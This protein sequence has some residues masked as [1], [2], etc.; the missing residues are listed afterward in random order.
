MPEA[1]TTESKIVCVHQGKAR[2]TAGQSKLK[3]GGAPAL[4]DGD[5]KQATLEPASCTNVGAGLVPCS[6]LT[7]L[8]GGVAAKLTVGGLGVLLADLKG[9]TN[10]TAPGTFLVEDAAQTRLRAV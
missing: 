1:I 7:P 2:L 4:V 9:S 5:I 8:P 3:I 6:V 10:S